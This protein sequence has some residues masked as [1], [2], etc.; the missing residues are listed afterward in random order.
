MRA[1]AARA[2]ARG[3]RGAQVGLA[4]AARPLGPLLL[5]EGGVPPRAHHS[6]A[7]AAA[8]PKSVWGRTWPTSRSPFLVN[9]TTEGVVRPPSALVMM[10]GLPPSMAATAELVVPRSMP[11]TCAPHEASAS[12]S[13]ARRGLRVAEGSSRAMRSAHVPSHPPCPRGQPAQNAWPQSV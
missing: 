3:D 5:Q 12:V 10:V 1:L 6:T 8:R 13:R 4:A 9:A 7:A 2:Q 11:T